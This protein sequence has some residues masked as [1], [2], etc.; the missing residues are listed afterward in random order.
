MLGSGAFGSVC[1][2]EYENQAVV[3]KIMKRVP[4]TQKEQK[5]FAREAYV[6]ATASEYAHVVRFLGA[7]VASSSS[8]EWCLVYQYLPG[9]SVENVLQRQHKYNST[10]LYDVQRVLRMCVDAAKGMAYLHD[11]CKI[12]HRDIAMRNLLL[13]SQERVW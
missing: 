8:S 3:V 4:Q 7:C 1:Y 9:G 2:G 5:S 11:H 6:S 13:D 12:V 10:D